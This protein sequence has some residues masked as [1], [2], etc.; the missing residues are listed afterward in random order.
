MF[1]FALLALLVGRF[2]RVLVLRLGPTR[3]NAI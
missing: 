2:A 3:F 1:S